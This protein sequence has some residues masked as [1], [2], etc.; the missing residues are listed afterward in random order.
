MPNGK[1]KRLRLPAHLQSPPFEGR[2]KNHGLSYLR[3]NYWR[4]AAASDDEDL[5]QDAYLMY[6]RVRRDHPDITKTAEFMRL[7]RPA[8]YGLLVWRSRQCFPNP[9]NMGEKARCYSLDSVI[10]AN[11]EQHSCSEI[12]ESRSLFGILDSEM[13]SYLRLIQQLPLEL[14]EAFILLIK[15]F[16]GQEVI[17]LRTSKK[18]KGKTWREPLAIAL[19]RKVGYDLSRDLIHEIGLVLGVT[20]TEARSTEG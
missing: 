18:L 4:M 2:I 14:Q 10:Y 15:E 20:T 8:L 16:N 12:S 3:K 1:R 9:F 7:Y 6:L 19:A 5:Q 17:P 11:G 13:G